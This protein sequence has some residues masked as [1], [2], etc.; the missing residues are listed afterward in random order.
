MLFGNTRQLLGGASGDFS[1]ALFGRLGVNEAATQ[2]IDLTGRRNR[3]D[4]PL[5]P[6]LVVWLVLAMTL[7]R[8]LSIGNVFRK[9]VALIQEREPELVA[10]PVTDEAVIHAKARLGFEPFKLLFESLA[11]RGHGTVHFHGYRVWGIDGVEF[12]L[13]DSPANVARFPKAKPKQGT[14]AFPSLRA[15]CLVNTVNRKVRDVS[16]SPRSVAETKHLETLLDR[17]LGSGDIVIMDR[18]LSA[19]W[20]FTVCEHLDVDFLARIPVHWTFIEKQ[21]LGTGDSIVSLRSNFARR[22]SLEKRGFHPRTPVIARK[23]TYKVGGGQTVTLLTSLTDA[24]LFPARELALLYHQRWECEL[25]YNEMKNHLAV[26]CHARQ[27]TVFRSKRPDGVLQ[28]AYSLMIVYN[29]LRE[30]ILEAS[31]EADAQPLEFSFT[32]A[33]QVIE[34]W[35]P[36]IQ[37]ACGCRRHRMWRRMLQ[38]LVQ[39]RMKRSRRPRRCPRKVKKKM[40]RYHVKRESDVEEKLNFKRE[41][42]LVD[43]GD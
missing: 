4:C 34:V 1:I 31:S 39:C 25:V 41:L 5:K 28:E 22:C 18:G 6:M 27:R 2:A 9:L 16:F 3:R 36:R 11:G 13:P 32:D 21:R 37:A 30:L 12:T 8:R 10:R 14:S 19:S 29:L 7:H 15:V 23:I 40:T 26:A 17:N 43:V 42:K 20:V 24:K 38:S 33:L 35:T